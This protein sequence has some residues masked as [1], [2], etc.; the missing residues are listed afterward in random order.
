MTSPRSTITNFAAPLLA[1]GVGLVFAGCSH[2]AD[3]GP[4]DSPAAQPPPESSS[5]PAPAGYDVSRVSGVKGDFPPGFDVQTEPEKTLSQQDID[6]SGIGAFTGAAVG[7]PQCRAMLIP[8]N[9]EPSVGTRA[10]GV[11][12][13]GDQGNMFV[14]ALT[15]PQ[16]VTAG[17]PPDCAHASVSGGP[18][19]TGTAEP[20]PAPHIDGATTTGVKLT[21]SDQDPDFIFTAALDSQTSVIAMGTA[22]A[23]LNPQQVLSDLLVKAVGAVRGQ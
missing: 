19:V 13:S 17:A 1:L 20:V 22:D 4:T 10:A 7:P 14:V 12:G 5:T 8:P 21:V 23:D 15:L 3:S 16:P 18:E 11:H 9:A 2:S 6:N